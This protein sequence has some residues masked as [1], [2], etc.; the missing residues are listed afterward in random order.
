MTL[1]DRHLALRAAAQ[2]H[3]RLCAM[4]H[5]QTTREQLQDWLLADPLH[6]WAWQRVERLQAG[7]QGISGGLARYTLS[8]DASARGRRALL[9][10]ML[11]GLGAAGLAWGGYQRSPVWLADLRTAIGERRNLLLA[12][13]SRLFLNTGSAVDIRYDADQ[14]LILLRAGEILVETAADPRPLSVRSPHGDMRALGTRFG[15]RLFDDH[16]RLSVLEHAV[17]VSNAS[18]GTP[19]RV[20]A[21]MGLDFDTGPLPAP[22]VTDVSQGAWSQGRL[23]VDDWRLDRTLAELER[24]RRGF[25]RCDESIAGLR[26]SGV[27]PLDDIDR[28]LQVIAQALKLQMH[29]RTRFWTRFTAAA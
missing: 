21:G 9:K 28:T 17:A 22:H 26:V 23:V 27:Y 15:I 24:Y 16:T 11:F 5:C 3:A 1:S 6:P 20:D 13:G 25:I 4:P 12:D 10:G 19:L 14:R 29:T 7:L 8:T 18:A 2:W